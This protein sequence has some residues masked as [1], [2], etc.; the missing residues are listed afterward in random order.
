ME[1]HSD[2]DYPP[3]AHNK[4][5]PPVELR[6]LTILR[7]APIAFSIRHP[8]SA[9]SLEVEIVRVLQE[10][11]VV[12]RSAGAHPTED[13]GCY[14]FHHTEGMADGFYRLH[15][16][17]RGIG[18]KSVELPPCLFEVTSAEPIQPP[19]RGDLAQRYRSIV[20][21]RKQALM[22]GIGEAGSA[23]EFRAQVLVK[24]LLVTQL[25]TLDRFILQPLGGYGLHELQ[26]FAKH[27]LGAPVKFASAAARENPAAVA[28]FP[29]VRA[30]TR[31]DAIVLIERHLEPFLN[32]LA[33]ER[34]GYPTAV[35]AALTNLQSGEK[36]L[37]PLSPRYRGSILGGEM[38]GEDSPHL[39]WLA[40][41]L[42]D[43]PDLALY[44]RL[45]R[46]AREERRFEFAYFRLWSL[47][48]TMARELVAPGEY[49][50][51]WK[52]ALITNKQGRPVKV[53]TQASPLV[54]Q[55][56]RRSF[57]GDVSHVWDVAGQRISLDDLVPIWYRHRNC[58]G[59]RGRCSPDDLALCERGSGVHERC[60]AMHE[61]IVALRGVRSRANDSCLM[62]L[63]DV[64][65]LVIFRTL[66]NRM[67]PSELSSPS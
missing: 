14:T 9:G 18:G 29:L 28:L 56:I 32:V 63:E 23:M 19:N 36:G 21:A 26:R 2:R 60:R 17:A 61:Q 12:V 24:D 45:F 16:R 50:V 52:N 47:L 1:K 10:D 38:G 51:D 41:V 35:A 46:Q 22:A 53:G 62:T 49:R 5:D 42:R 13:A 33:A 39:R 3:A 4:D 30:S 34:G 57:A 20:S 7:G 8:I 25:L 65:R 66:A 58:V 31:D 64:T 48:E 59:H 11:D 43:Q 6:D 67:P 15:V 40:G 27:A 54:T 37:I 44:L 55:L